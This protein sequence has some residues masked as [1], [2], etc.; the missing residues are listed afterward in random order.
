MLFR[1]KPGASEAKDKG[2]IEIAVQATPIY[3]PG[4]KAEHS[5]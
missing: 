1:A 3:T 4:G 2:G 5:K